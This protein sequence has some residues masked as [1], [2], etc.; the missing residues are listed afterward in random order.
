MA[1]GFEKIQAEGNSFIAEIALALETNDQEKAG[2][3]LRS[4]LRALRNRL[5]VEESFE[6]IAQLPLAIKAV[7]VDGWKVKLNP[8]KLKHI[9]DFRKE[10]YNEDELS[11][12]NDFDHDGAVDEAIKAVFQVLSKYIDAAEIDNVLDAIPAALRASLEGEDN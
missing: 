6:F 7:Y 11:A 9:E 12:A 1:L 3:I 2:R 5:T 10:V 4:V 8:S